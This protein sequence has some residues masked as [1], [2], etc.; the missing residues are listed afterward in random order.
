MPRLIAKI[1][2]GVLRYDENQFI[3]WAEKQKDGKYA[4]SIKK[5]YKPRSL[6]ENAYYWGVVIELLCGHTGYTPEE[7][8][9]CL[10]AK[11]LPH[12]VDEYGLE[13]VKSTTKLSTVE[14]ET[15][16]EDI[17][18]WASSELDVYIPDPE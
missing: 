16:M 17:R 9:D 18:R 12:G 2:N 6:Q 13:H 5:W 15:Y 3:T 7:M 4:L 10:K 11:F 8:H 1:I 14:F